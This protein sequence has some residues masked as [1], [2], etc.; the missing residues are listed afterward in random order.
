MDWEHLNLQYWSPSV[1]FCHGDVSADGPVKGTILTLT[2]QSLM[3]CNSET[4][5]VQS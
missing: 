4:C 5:R 1:K 3:I 2:T